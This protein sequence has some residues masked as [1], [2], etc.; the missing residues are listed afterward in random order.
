MKRIRLVAYKLELY[1]EMDKIHNVFHVSMLKKYTPDPSHVLQTPPVELSSDLSFE[2][3]PVEIL[4]RQVRVLRNK[5]I[6]MVK[7]LWRS[8]HVEEVT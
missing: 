4:D 1:S 7:V 2:V 3:Q 5:T 8:A 6:P